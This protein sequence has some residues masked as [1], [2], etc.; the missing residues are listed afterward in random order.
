VNP[1]RIALTLLALALA[2]A[3][4]W[5]TDWGQGFGETNIGEKNVVA[6]AESATVLPDFKLGSDASA[7]AAIA[8]KP[9]LNPTRKPAPTQA[10]AVAAPEPPKP[11]IRRG[12]YQLV[13]VSDLGSVKIAQV[14]E[15]AGGKVRSV[16][17]GENLQELR[18]A[19]ID[20]NAVTLEFQGETDVLEIAKYTASGRVPQQPVPP[21]PIAGAQPPVPPQQMPPGIAPQPVPQPNVAGLPRPAP[22]ADG[23]ADPNLPPGAVVNRRTGAVTLPGQR[24]DVASV[25]EI[26]RRRRGPEQVQGQQ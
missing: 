26:A 1:L 10:V 17:A 6:K 19:K 8:E 23:V 3:L 2:G 14:R 9:L 22:G 16:R 7:Y 12:L 4:G 21:P 20:L 18:V 24:S 5:M 25:G 15:V 11:Q 13:G